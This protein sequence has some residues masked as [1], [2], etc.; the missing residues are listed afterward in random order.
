MGG[1][2]PGKVAEYPVHDTQIPC[3]ASFLFCEP[4]EW[5]DVCNVRGSGVQAIMH[6]ILGSACTVTYVSCVQ[7]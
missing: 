6:V 2:T 3:N 7:Y 5:T 1:G 4:N